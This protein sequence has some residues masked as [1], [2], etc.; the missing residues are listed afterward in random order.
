MTL[1]LKDVLFGRKKKEDEGIVHPA[2]APGVE[3]KNRSTGTIGKYEIVEKIGSGGFGTVYKAWDPVIKRH[4]AIKTC[5][6]G[7]KDI[8]NRFLR[9]AQLAG[10]LQHPNITLVYEFGFEG[11]VPYMVQ[12]FLS[13]EDLDRV[14]KRDAPLPLQDKLRILIGVVFGLEYA[15]KAGI[16]HRD[17][18]PANVRVLD[19]RSVKIMDFGIAK[20]VE[21]ADDITQTGITV[22]SSS[23]MSPEQ[24]GGDS[25]DFRTDIF[26]FGILAYELFSSRKPFH[27][28][29]LFLLLEQIVKEP[30]EPL[31]ELV[32]ELP[33]PLV[34]L[35]ERAMQKRP[36]DRFQSAKE[37]RN[38]LVSI[39]QEIAPAEAALADALTAERP[40]TESARLVALE[41]LEILDTGPEREFDD[42][43]RLASQ[44]CGTPVA[45]ISFLDRD[46]EWYKSA[47][48]LS[49]R[50][51][52]RILAFSTD[53]M[54]KRDVLI[55]PD[56]ASDARFA[57]NPLVA[58][59]PK[60]RFC[61]AAPLLTSEGFAVGMLCVL[62]REPRELSQS[63]LDGLQTLARQVMAQVELKQLRRSGREESSEKLMLEVAGL[64][65]RAPSSPEGEKPL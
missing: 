17:I 52:P 53:A 46:R 26:S 10:G 33:L 29:N 11:D 61:V 31:A 24:I 3:G 16:M 18:K 22:G 4:V 42:L 49:L 36:E 38:A 15:H 48:G 8:R 56:L 30:P 64:A 60:L 50:E 28:D 32:P 45:L 41:R 40:Q 35:V 58:G 39:Q 47:I 55:L 20:S 2:D 59:D 44:L 54:L 34:L 25:V 62:D 14:I 7:S 37:L 12:E 19:T 43:A 5:E 51:V 1:K 63:Q 13:G 23:Y 27:N 9:E 57:D 6:V 21:P 65:D